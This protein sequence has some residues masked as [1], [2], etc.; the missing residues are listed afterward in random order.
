MVGDIEVLHGGMGP[1]KEVDVLTN[2]LLSIQLALQNADLETSAGRARS[3]ALAQ[4][5]ARTP[6][7]PQVNVGLAD[8]LD[9]VRQDIMDR[10]LQLADM[11]MRR[12]PEA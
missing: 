1:D 10:E 3:E 5:P 7:A 11:Q 4:L 8:R 2:S 12:T 9:R 6:G